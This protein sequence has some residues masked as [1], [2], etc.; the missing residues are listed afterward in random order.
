MFDPAF[1]EHFQVAR[2]SQH[3]TALLAGVP[4]AFVGSRSR[5][6]AAVL[7]LCKELQAEFCTKGWPLPP[8]R[9]LQAMLTRFQ[10]A[11]HR[12]ASQ[13]GARLP[14]QEL[15]KRPAGALFAPAPT[16]LGHTFLFGGLPRTIRPLLM[17]LG[18]G[19]A[20]ALPRCTC[21][22]TSTV[23]GTCSGLQPCDLCR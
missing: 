3:Y 11:A 2:P 15:H 12:A 21:T 7:L 13:P 9:Q 23:T 20:K 8:W 4:A 6:T 19:F 18:S 17:S 14:Q 16:A 1:R 22:A 10:P 5:L